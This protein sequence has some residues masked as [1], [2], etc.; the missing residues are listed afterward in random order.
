MHLLDNKPFEDLV[1]TLWNGWN[2]HNNAILQ[3]KEEEAQIVWDMAKTLSD[4]F[5]IHNM[6]N[7]SF[8][9]LVSRVQKWEKM[10]NGYVKINMDAVSRTIKL[11]LGWITSLI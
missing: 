6:V 11:D 10:P 7:K 9:P 3:G 4:D 5:H 1:T 8:L 2:N